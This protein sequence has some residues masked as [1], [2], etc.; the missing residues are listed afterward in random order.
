MTEE[1]SVN[2]NWRAVVLVLTILDLV[3]FIF[4][5]GLVYGRTDK[6]QLGII[7]MIVGTPAA[8]VLSIFLLYLYIQS[9]ENNPFFNPVGAIATN[10]PFTRL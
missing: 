3:V 6:Q 8:F 7:L 1:P 2:V 10:Q 9:L 4:G 5:F